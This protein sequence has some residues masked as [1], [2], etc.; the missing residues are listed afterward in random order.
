MADLFLDPVCKNVILKGGRMET[1]MSVIG[2]KEYHMA[3]VK[4]QYLLMANNMLVNSKRDVDPALELFTIQTIQ[5]LWE[6]FL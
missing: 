2:S 5:V 1:F 4:W 6:D 3:M